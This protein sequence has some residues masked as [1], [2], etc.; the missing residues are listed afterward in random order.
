M[1]DQ[2]R[3]YQCS[4]IP[5]KYVYTIYVFFLQKEAE[6]YSLGYF[7]LREF[8]L[9]GSWYPRGHVGT[10]RSPGSSNLSQQKPRRQ[11]GDL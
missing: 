8:L 6:R 9:F 7:F 2:N 5:Y 4:I 1:I 10:D 3:T 11:S